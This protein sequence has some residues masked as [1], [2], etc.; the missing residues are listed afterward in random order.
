MNTLKENNH[1]I[2]NEHKIC[3]IICT[4]D[5]QQLQECLL[6]LSLLKVPEGYETELLTITDAKS[7]TSGYNEAMNASDA[8]YKIYLHQDSFIV[9]RDFLDEMLKLF[10]KDKKIGM[11]GIVGAEKLSKDGVMW[12]EQ[13][14]GNFYRLD[15]LIKG[16]YDSIVHLKRGI[17][18]VEVIDG[19]FMATQYD[20]PWREDLL[21][22]WDF[23]DVS[24]C[25]EFRRAGY[26]IVVPGQKEV[27]V[28][29]VCGA[30]SFWHYNQYRELVLGEYPEIKENQP[31][32]LRIAFIHSTQ[33]KLIGLP[34]A[35]QEMGHSV[36]IPEGQVELNIRRQC[37]V[38]TVEEILEEG[39]YDLV[40]TYDFSSGV[41][42]A[43][44]NM[45]VKYYAWTYD[46]PLMALYSEQAL[47]DSCY[48]SVFDKKQL[49]RLQYRGMKHLFHLPLASEVETF[50]SVSIKKRDEKKLITDI[51]FVGRLYDKRGYERLFGEG[52]EKLQKEADAL[53]ASLNC[54]W[55]GKTDLFGQASDELIAH[56]ISKEPKENWKEW[57]IDKRY[58]AESLM[59]IRRCNELERIK[60][61]NFLAEKYKITLYSDDSE[62]PMLKNVV[63]RPWVDYLQ[64]MPKV[65]YLS[66]I[67]LNIS[68][69][70][71][72][73][74]VPQRVWDILSV[75]GFCLSNYQ[76]ELEDYFEFGKDLDVF[77][78]LEELDEKVAYYLKHEEERVRIAIN[79]YKKM[80]KYHD[81]KARLTKALE[82]IYSDETL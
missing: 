72:E 61:L 29:H 4:N 58:Y 63:V 36:T 34:F 1:K 77:H 2:Y 74:G 62:K 40:V 46:S 44:D 30:P 12:H 82:Y 76:P 25:M 51:S 52:D 37:D 21:D 27:W 41:A 8:K 38:D 78:N 57:H 18:E 71:I 66:K 50:G 14:C 67:N 39:H 49:E 6:Y 64:E 79:G 69:R 59:L 60:I 70:S 26:K 17:K 43:C 24:Q 3:F 48:I 28:N 73:S 20:I 23:Y 31:G 45:G 11:M 56:I 42:E 65:F 54:V 32:R 13:R 16:G 10:K 81:I 68:S 75:G 33:I 80:R 15:E 9:K 35:L 47:L 19:F 53:V 22:G 55:D 7:M 5:E